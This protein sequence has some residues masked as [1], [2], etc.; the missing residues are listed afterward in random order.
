M[1]FSGLKSN[2]KRIIEKGSF[3]ESNLC[4]SL[5]DVVART[6]LSKIKLAITNDN[7]NTLV[8]AGGVMSNDFLRNYLKDNLSNFGFKNVVFPKKNDC[9]DNAL[10]VAINCYYKIFYLKNN[11]FIEH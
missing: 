2:I 3:N 6:L 4:Y 10:M 11:V 7:Y 1:S 5:Q 9:T 8:L